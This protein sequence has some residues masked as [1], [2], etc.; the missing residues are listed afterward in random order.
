MM[1]TTMIGLPFV[2]AALVALSLTVRVRDYELLT[3][4]LSLACE[5]A[6]LACGALLPR[7]AL[8][9]AS[10]RWYSVGCGFALLTLT[11]LLLLPAASLAAWARGLPK[12]GRALRA[13]ARVGALAIAAAGAAAAVGR[14]PLRAL[15][16]DRGGVL[17]WRATD[18]AGDDDGASALDEALATLARGAASV[19]YTHLT[20][21]TILLV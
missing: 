10:F 21:P 20:L 17:E 3:V 12:R 16:R 8:D 13:L 11:P 19:S 15:A 9:T 1:T 14:L 2:L 5:D 18:G 7:A 6:R 4:A